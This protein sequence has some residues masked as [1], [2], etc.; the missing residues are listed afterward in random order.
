MKLVEWWDA[1]IEIGTAGTIATNAWPTSKGMNGY[2]LNRFKVS[3]GEVIIIIYFIYV[4]EKADGSW[5]Q[6]S[7]LW[8]QERAHQGR[9]LPLPLI[10][11]LLS[12]V[13]MH[14]IDTFQTGVHYLTTYPPM[15]HFSNL[16]FSPISDEP[17]SPM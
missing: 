9:E 13:R 10:C 2:D 11:C 6:T 17:A 8:E 15:E 5:A 16:E 12:S 7:S 4:C 1:A 3:V 14:E